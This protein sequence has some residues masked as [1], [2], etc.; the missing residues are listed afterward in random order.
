MFQAPGNRNLTLKYR[1]DYD[2]LCGIRLQKMSHLFYRCR[3]EI[4]LFKCNHPDRMLLRPYTDL[5]RQWI[6]F[7]GDTSIFS[8]SFR[9]VI[10]CN[11]LRLPSAVH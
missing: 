9:C 2:Q 10:G 5:F 3:L 8:P 1:I 7:N 4:T 11:G 6:D